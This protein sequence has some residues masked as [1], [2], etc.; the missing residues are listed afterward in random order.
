ME[1]LHSGM[2]KELRTSDLPVR[3]DG[4]QDQELAV[5]HRMETNDVFSS[6]S[7]SWSDRCPQLTQLAQ[8]APR[9]SLLHSNA[10]FQC[11]EIFP[12]LLQIDT[13]A[14]G[15]VRQIHSVIHRIFPIGH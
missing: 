9:L 2:H 1:K 6:I 11:N 8:L 4:I 7:S 3:T 13:S 15:R 10:S 5:G 14:R 12:N